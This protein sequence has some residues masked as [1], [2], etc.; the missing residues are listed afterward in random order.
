MIAVLPTTIFVVTLP[1]GSWARVSFC[2]TTYGYTSVKKSLLEFGDVF[3]GRYA[4]TIG[5]QRA[6]DWRGSVWV[7]C[8]APDRTTL[9]SEALEIVVRARRP[10]G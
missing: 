6:V 8:G 2:S 10:V 4:M 5:E 3:P 9:E 1:Y 7:T